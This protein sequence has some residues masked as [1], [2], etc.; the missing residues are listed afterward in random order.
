MSGL[1]PGDQLLG[2]E[3]NWEIEMEGLCRQRPCRDPRET[4]QRSRKDERVLGLGE[5]V[6]LSSFLLVVVF[7]CDGPYP[8]KKKK[9]FHLIR[10]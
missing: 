3:R 6:F 1:I 5:L 8:L 9:D 10:K 4:L 7:P 2:L